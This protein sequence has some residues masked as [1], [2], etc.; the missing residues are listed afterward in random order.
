MLVDSGIVCKEVFSA[1]TYIRFQMIRSDYSHRQPTHRPPCPH[2]SIFVSITS[3]LE[4]EP[5]FDSHIQLLLR[6]P[7]AYAS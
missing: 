3:L 7:A 6:N 2:L 1:F 5:L 4:E